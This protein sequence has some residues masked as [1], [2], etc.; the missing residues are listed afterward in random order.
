MSLNTDAEWPVILRFRSTKQVQEAALL[1]KALDLPYTLDW[2]GE[3]WVFRVEPKEAERALE[4]WEAYRKEN[5][6]WPPSQSWKNLKESGAKGALPLFLFLV[7]SYF[8]QFSKS[9]Q[10]QRS[11]LS[12]VASIPLKIFEDGEFFRVLTALFFHADGLH[13]L[14]NLVAGSIFLAL[15]L[16]S[17]GAGLSAASFF[18]SGAMGNLLNASFYSEVPRTSIGAST[19]NFGLIGVLTGWRLIENLK[20]HEKL[21]LRTLIIPL[22]AGLTFL[23]LMGSSAESDYMA[24]FWGFAAG[25]L[26]GFLVALTRLTE[27]L[28]SRAQRLI[29][30]LIWICA[31]GILFL[32][33]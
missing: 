18:A 31:F 1:F 16:P 13:L 5:R 14:S 17:L 19:A 25:L 29:A 23:G 22:G 27:L 4:Q 24:H 21:D 2:D 33:A 15:A 3:H 6:G 7:T 30:S 28:N 32:V 26:L 11:L 10:E 12:E 8:L 20:K 9:Y